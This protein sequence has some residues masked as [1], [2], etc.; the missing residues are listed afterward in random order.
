MYGLI[1][2]WFLTDCMDWKSPGNSFI[3]LAQL[4]AMHASFAEELFEL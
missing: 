1:R 2:D 4:F 3:L